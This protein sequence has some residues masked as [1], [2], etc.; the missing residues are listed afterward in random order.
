MSGLSRRQ[1]LRI[2]AQEQLEFREAALRSVSTLYFI[3]NGAMV[4][5]NGET[6][7][8]ICFLFQGVPSELKTPLAVAMALSDHELGTGH[9]KDP[10]SSHANEKVVVKDWVRRL[11]QV[12]NFFL[13]FQPFKNP[14]HSLP[15]S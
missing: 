3:Q 10:W 8:E 11:D 1:I 4:L 15:D 13:Q 14:S 2:Q 12:G 5:L 6:L 7:Q 9:S